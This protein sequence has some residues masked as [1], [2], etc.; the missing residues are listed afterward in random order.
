MNAS[1]RLLTFVLAA[2]R[3]APYPLTRDRAKPA[4][5]FGGVFRL[6]DF[7][8]SNV[9]KAGYRRIAVLTQY[10]SNSLNR[11]LT[12]TWQL[13]PLLGSCVTP[14]PAQMRSGL[15]G[16]RGPPTRSSRTST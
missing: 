16:T 15:T 4:V 11:H 2:A 14:V 10:K 12:Q 13:A 9:V 3:E 1:E 5:R 7:A 8:L 6:I